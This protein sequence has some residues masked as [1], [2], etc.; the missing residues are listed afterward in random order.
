MA[1]WKK[2]FKKDKNVVKPIRT[3]G[4]RSEEPE[5]NDDSMQ[6]KLFIPD[7]KILSHKEPPPAML[8]VLSGENAG[9]SLPV[10]SG[11]V[12]IGRMAGSELMLTDSSVSR[13]HAFIV[14]ENGCHI[15]CDNKSVNGTFLNS[16]KISRKDLQ[17]GDMVTVGNTVI[18]YE[19]R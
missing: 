13:L 11:Q 16:S 6:T 3:I 8:R 14:N 1:F 7:K 18:V 10:G 4:C 15:L 17:H 5:A 19:L 2:I 12:N 9:L